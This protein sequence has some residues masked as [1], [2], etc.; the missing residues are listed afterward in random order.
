MLNIFMG[1]SPLRELISPE[2]L[3]SEP[4]K[5]YE[6]VEI[7][8]NYCRGRGQIISN[9]EYSGRLNFTFSTSR[10]T[11]FIQFTDLI[12]RK[13]LFMILSNN[14]ARVWDI[15]HNQQ[16]DL[17]TIM[18]SFPLF[19]LIQPEDLRTLLWG[20]IPAAFHPDENNRMNSIKAGTIQF[21]SKQTEYGPLVSEINFT[22]GSQQKVKLT[23][24]VREFGS[25][26]PHLEREIPSAIPLSKMD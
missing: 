9:G 15:I 5:G 2:R 22:V 18:L 6:S 14:D 1:C 20:Q 13:S 11:A 24:I 16:Y 19:E 26:Y 23:I 25:T 8:E 10:D 4:V 12:G 7:T 17:A 3:A 21:Y